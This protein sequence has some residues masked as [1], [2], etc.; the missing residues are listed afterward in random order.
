VPPGPPAGAP[1][2]DGSRASSDRRDVLTTTRFA[3]RLLAR[4]VLS[5]TEEI[6]DLHT[7]L[8]LPISAHAAVLLERNGVGPDTAA[9]LLI[10]AGDNPDR[11]Q[12]P[13]SSSS[14]ARQGGACV[15]PKE[16]LL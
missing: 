16:L 15:L 2:S 9:A 5:L 3:L 14:S 1:P 11:L 10:A 12:G 13:R 4:R 7:R 8:T 6:D